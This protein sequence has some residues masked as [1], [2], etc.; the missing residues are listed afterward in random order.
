MRPLRLP[1]PRCIVILLLCLAGAMPLCGQ[2]AERMVA[3]GTRYR[4]EVDPAGPW[5]IHIVSIDRA[6]PLVSLA[7]TLGDGRILGCTALSA[8]ARAVTTPTRYPVA[9]VNADYF[10]MDSADRYRGDPLGLYVEEGELLSQPSARA[11]LL[12][13]DKGELAIARPTLECW[14]EHDTAGRFPITCLNQSRPAGGLTLYRP[15]F[16]ESTLTPATGVELTL[17]GLAGPL[18]PVGDY[19][20][21]VAAVN[22]GGNSLIPADGLVLSGS[23][24]AGDYLHRLAAGNRVRLHVA[25]TGCPFVPRFAVAGGPQILRGGRPAEGMADEGVTA[26]FINTRHPRTA[27]GF[28]DRTA[29][30][31]TVDG[32]QASSVGMSLPELAA[33]MQRLG[34]TE[35]L[36]LD[37]GGSTAL[38]L[39]GRIRN[40]PSDGR[41][42]PVADALALWSTAPLGPPH[43]LL[44]G[45]GPAVVLAGHRVPVTAEVEDQYYNPLPEAAITWQTTVGEVAAGIFV[46]R[47]GR[48]ELTACAG[49]AR[50]SRPVTVLERP[51]RVQVTGA[52]LLT[53]GG[54]ATY[55]VTAYGPAGETLPLDPALVQW[56]ATAGAI[57]GGDYQAPAEPAQVT[58]T[59][60]VNGVAGALAVQV[61]EMTWRLV[62]DFEGGGSWSAV[63]YPPATVQAFTA[64]VG[65]AYS[66]KQG[67]ELAYDLKAAPQ[68]G[69]AYARLNT[70]LG[71]ARLLRL[72]V[73][74]DGSNLWLRAKLR[75]DGAPALTVTLAPKVDWQGEWKLLTAEVPAGLGS[76]VTLESVYVVDLHPTSRQGRLLFDRLEVAAFGP[77][78]Q[79]GNTMDLPRHTIRR[80]A[81]PIRVDGVLDEPIWRQLDPLKL[82]LADGA[83]E[84]QQETEV[85]LCWDDACLYTAFTAIDTDIWGT[86]RRRDEPLFDE[87]V[88]EIFL[89]PTGSLTDYFELEVSPHNVVWD[90]RIHNPNGSRQGLQ[91]NSSWDC[92]GLQTAVRVVGTLDKRDDLDQLWTVE[93]AIPFAAI[94]PGAKPPRV[95]DTW[96]GNLYRIDRGE[97][98]EFTAWSPTMVRPASFHVP[99][100]FGY[101]VFGDEKGSTT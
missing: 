70:P 42:R 4:H 77:A 61:G 86:Y 3:P 19:E 31:V 46:P 20:L 47:A 68:A 21:T 56:Q 54:K 99:A 95:G 5:D 73:K 12:I 89:S 50:A 10:S 98:D 41:E 94:T 78:P 22:E 40:S 62:E 24:P 39:R 58:V 66:G 43:H 60:T 2:P 48:G 53:P 96:R 9:L 83:G 55:A 57:S 1:L 30:L 67:L 71:A 34:A 80:I 92:E 81:G 38:W 44:L 63:A 85:K 97:V 100:C 11:G 74:G 29:F 79:G 90:G 45:E 82:V 72:R 49:E 25:L 93:M 28:N 101:F 23:G 75:G 65:E 59:A 16:G 76:D 17:T 32:R 8:M 51:S 13:G 84:P 36:N 64:V 6:E 88:V 15:L 35:A 87:E 91:G 26:S 52:E 14:V 18:A 37:G 27:V 33:L 7:P 69:A